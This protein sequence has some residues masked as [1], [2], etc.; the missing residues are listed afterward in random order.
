L[1]SIKVR[2][3]N[4]LKNGWFYRYLLMGGIAF[5][6]YTAEELAQEFA[7]VYKV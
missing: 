3:S 7:G 2:Y 6:D 1:A 5:I 4:K